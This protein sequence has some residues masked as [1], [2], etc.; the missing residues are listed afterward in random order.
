[1]GITI[2]KIGLK[3]K[4]YTEKLKVDPS[5]QSFY[6]GEGWIGILKELIDC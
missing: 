1:M 6:I 3:N 2:K 4:L 5:L